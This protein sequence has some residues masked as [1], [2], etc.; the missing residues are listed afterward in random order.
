MPR[1]RHR[2]PEAAALFHE[3]GSLAV[4]AMPRGR[5][6]SLSPLRVGLGIANVSEAC[7]CDRCI[8][9]DLEAL[10]TLR[11]V[12][13]CLC[14]RGGTECGTLHALKH[15][16]NH[17]PQ[18]RLRLVKHWAPCC[19]GAAPYSTLKAQ[20]LK[21]LHFPGVAP[22]GLLKESRRLPVPF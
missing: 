17:C 3:E 18:N 14:H 16:V 10:A 2:Q 1:L 20:F 15:D 13:R 21:L 9:C 22:V 11:M 7:F 6:Q 4:Q 12:C 19:D 8:E 5:G